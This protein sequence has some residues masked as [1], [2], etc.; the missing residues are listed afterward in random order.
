MQNSTFIGIDPGWKNLG[1]AILKK[2]FN[3]G[4]ITLCEARVLV[5]ASH[6]SVVGFIE[7][8]DEV[9]FPWTHNLKGVT[10][11]RFV[12]YSNVFTSEA[13]SINQVIGAL[14]YYFGAKDSWN[15]EPTLIR[16]IDWKIKLVKHLVTTK[17]FNNPSNSLDKK[18]TMA[19]ATACV[20]KDERT[21]EPGKEAPPDMTDHEG[22]AICLGYLGTV[23]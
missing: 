15:T 16:A 14:H 7:E 12:P 17:N 1:L 6:K 4:H 5:P 8:L 23:T 10:I 2:D 11:E 13:E 22:D 3:T 9:I 21:I 18:F 20:D 19:A